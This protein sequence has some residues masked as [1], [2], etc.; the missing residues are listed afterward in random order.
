MLHLQEKKIPPE[1]VQLKKT[2]RNLKTRKW[3]EEGLK[4][5]RQTHQQKLEK[6]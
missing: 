5:L 3:T 6:R 4:F 1:G 2:L